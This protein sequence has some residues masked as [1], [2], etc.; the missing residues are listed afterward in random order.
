[1]VGLLLAIILF[2]IIAFKSNKRLTVKQIAH[3]WVFTI[4]FQMSADI[5]IDIKYQG[6]WYFRP[7]VDWA[8]LPA[9]IAL[10]PPVN[11][12]FLNWYPFGSSLGK[13][14]VYFFYWE[15]ALLTYE[16]LTLIPEPWGYFHY[17]WWNLGYSAVVDPILLMI[18]LVYY[19]KFIK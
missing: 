13:Q 14:A 15:I 5:F 4:A 9:H 19:K 2:N 3:I 10:L 11:M 16:L 17:G 7:E 8:A 6:Y 18:L 12:M 1:M